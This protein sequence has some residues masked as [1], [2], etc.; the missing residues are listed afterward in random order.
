[1]LCNQWPEPRQGTL[2]TSYNFM[3]FCSP[4]APKKHLGP[5]RMAQEPPKSHP[6]QLR[7]AQEPPPGR[8]M[9]LWTVAASNLSERRLDINVFFAGFREKSVWA[10][11]SRPRGPKEGSRVPKR[12]PRALHG[13]PEPWSAKDREKAQNDPQ[14]ARRPGEP[15]EYP[16][17]F[18]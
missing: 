16:T 1:M 14:E 2:G 5:L 9:Q 4:R 7:L 13:T 6:R 8:I 10:A 17:Y 12:N 3:F 15:Q 18:N 11:K